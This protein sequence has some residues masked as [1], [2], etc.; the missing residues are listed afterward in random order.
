MSDLHIILLHA[1]H[2]LVKGSGRQ[3]QQDAP[4]FCASIHKR[5]EQLLDMMDTVLMH[6]QISITPHH[7]LTNQFLDSCKDRSVRLRKKGHGPFLKVTAFLRESFN[8]KTLGP[9]PVGAPNF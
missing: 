2:L 6:M 5:R 1:K 4:H 7:E 8:L 3:S 9:P